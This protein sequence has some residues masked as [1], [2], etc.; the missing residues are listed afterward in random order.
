[1][2][3]IN[4][5][6]FG[7]LVVISAFIMIIP[8]SYNNPYS[9]PYMVYEDNYRVIKLLETDA[10]QQKLHIKLLQE[11]KTAIKG[12]IISG[13]DVRVSVKGDLKPDEAK[14]ISDM[15]LKE[16]P[17]SKLI[18]LSDKGE[19]IYSIQNEVN[20]APDEKVPRQK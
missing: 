17:R 9:D 3:Y 14:F 8:T 1:M 7:A 5:L 20:K 4:Y 16:Y 15:V 12:V 19:I 2:N 6:G 11:T 18:L 10:L 13:Y